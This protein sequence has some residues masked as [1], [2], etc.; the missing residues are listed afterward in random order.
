MSKCWYCGRIFKDSESTATTPSKLGYGYCSRMC[1]L[2][3]KRARENEKN[4]NTIAEASRRAEAAA[5]EQADAERESAEAARRQ[6]RAYEEMQRSQEE[7][8]RNRQKQERLNNNTRSIQERAKGELED[9]S[10]MFVTKNGLKYREAVVGSSEYRMRSCAVSDFTG[11]SETSRNSSSTCKLMVNSVLNKTPKGSGCLHFNIYYLP[12]QIRDPFTEKPYNFDYSSTQYNEKNLK[13]A[14]GVTF[15]QKNDSC[16]TAWNSLGF[17]YDSDLCEPDY[18]SK[19]KYYPIYSSDKFNL[20]EAEEINNKS[21]IMKRTRKPIAP[22]YYALYVALIETLANGEEEIVAY[23]KTDGLHTTINKHLKILSNKKFGKIGEKSN[24]IKI[25]KFDY[26]CSY[27]ERKVS[28]SFSGAIWV[29][30]KTENANDAPGE[31]YFTVSLKDYETGKTEPLVTSDTFRTSYIPFLFN[32]SS[33]YVCR[34]RINIPVSQEGFYVAEI[35]LYELDENGN[36]RL[37]DTVTKNCGS[38]K[39]CIVNDRVGTRYASKFKVE[40]KNT[41][42]SISGG[43]VTIKMDRLQNLG[44]YDTGALKICLE[45]ETNGK[46]TVAAECYRNHLMK[47]YGY[48]NVNVTVNYHKPSDYCDASIPIISVYTLDDRGYWVRNTNKDVEFYSKAEK[49]KIE[50]DKKKAEEDKKRQIAANNARI[51]ADKKN[52]NYQK[53]TFLSLPLLVAAYCAYKGIGFSAFVKSRG[54]IFV[55]VLFIL[56]FLSMKYGF[57]SEIYGGIKRE[58]DSLGVLAFFKG[59]WKKYG[60]KIKSFKRDPI[61]FIVGSVINLLFM[62]GEL[63]IVLIGAG[64]GIGII[65]LITWFVWCILG[66]F[67][68]ICNTPLIFGLYY[69]FILNYIIGKIGCR[70]KINHLVSLILSIANLAIPVVVLL[71]NWVIIPNYSRIDAK[72]K[73]RENNTKVEQVV[74]NTDVQQ[75]S[76]TAKSNE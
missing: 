20:N 25:S 30:D 31:L 9:L 34:K 15:W 52:Y 60:F 63:V 62:L 36:G 54:I 68:P 66:W 3:A 17:S 58:L 61:D 22:G 65:A 33:S 50:A 6:A 38:S 24:A 21:F 11:D 46:R 1:E 59:L 18:D 49:A 29:N 10:R 35:K 8:E 5:R 7:I 12:E 23:C 43:K 37:L 55:I 16:E 70:K 57:Y 47:D 67:M 13:G 39:L 45:Y 71:V 64:I 76:D 4:A 27:Y 40:C 72:L 53:Y 2:R 73:E 56:A 44:D 19:N 26:G 74:E 41:S 14:S 75:S 42:Y 48:P 69:V 28:F 51:K 32:C